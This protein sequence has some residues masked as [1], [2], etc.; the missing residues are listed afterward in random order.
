[1][2][3]TARRQR[4]QLAVAH[5]GV[6][7]ADGMRLSTALYSCAVLHCLAAECGC[8][9]LICTMM[10]ISTLVQHVP[11][12]MLPPLASIYR[13]RYRGCGIRAAAHR[14]GLHV[15]PHGLTRCCATMD[16]AAC[17]CCDVLC[18]AC[19]SIYRTAH[20]QQIRLAVAHCVCWRCHVPQCSALLVGCA[21][22]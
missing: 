14:N 18:A 2:C 15:P 13:C 11:Y 12:R 9:V 6:Y 3:R 21:V 1:M 10:G 4:M 19:S 22:H 7:S 8:G 20:R 5:N 17:C 16:A